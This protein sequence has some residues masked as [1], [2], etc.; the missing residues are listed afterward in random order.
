MQNQ[1]AT[2]VQYGQ[3]NKKRGQFGCDEQDAEEEEE[4][5]EANVTNVFACVSV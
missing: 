2:N 5:E 4:E 1:E 3:C